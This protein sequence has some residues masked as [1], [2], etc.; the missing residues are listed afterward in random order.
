MGVILF[1]KGMKDNLQ[2]P[3]KARAHGHVT[4]SSGATQEAWSSDA[5]YLKRGLSP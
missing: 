3:V 5:K 2:A 4:G 1:A